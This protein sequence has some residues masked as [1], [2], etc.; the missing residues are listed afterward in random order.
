MDQ[1]IERLK[2]PQ[3]LPFWGDSRSLKKIEPNFVGTEI[4]EL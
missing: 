4:V 1:R 2:I 3:F